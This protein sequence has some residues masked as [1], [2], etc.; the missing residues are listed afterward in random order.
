M[1]I[2]LSEDHS[3]YAVGSQSHVTFLDSRNGRCV[4]SVHSK[5]R[6][7]GMYKIRGVFHKAVRKVMHDFTYDLNMKS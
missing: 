7:S 4:A 6:G 1:C 5:E 3:L 2:S